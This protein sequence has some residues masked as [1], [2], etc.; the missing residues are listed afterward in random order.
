MEE[1]LKI[2]ETEGRDIEKICLK[3]G[4]GREEVLGVLKKAEEEGIILGYRAIINWKKLGKEE[5]LAFVEVKVQP[6]KDVGFDLL[7]ERIA[8][9][10]ET[11]FVYLVSGTY[12]LA[13]LVKGR[14][15]EEVSSFI[16]RKIAP[17]EGVQGTIT[18]FVLKKYKEN[19]IFFEEGGERRIPLSL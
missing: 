6:R 4:R 10:P 5:V 2:A 7:A 16:S 8:R 3:T 9:F 19:G 15:M 1:I 13:V 11:V 14:S 17:M 18:H 12:D